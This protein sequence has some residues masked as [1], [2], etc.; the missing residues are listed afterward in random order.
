MHAAPAGWRLQPGQ[1]WVYAALLPGW[2]VIPSRASSNGPTTNAM[3]SKQ[4]DGVCVLGGKSVHYHTINPILNPSDHVL[5]YADIELQQVIQ[6]TAHCVRPRFLD[7]TSH[8]L[9]GPVV[10]DLGR[11][12]K[13]T[14]YQRIRWR[15]DNPVRLTQADERQYL[16]PTAEGSSWVRI[17]YKA[18]TDMRNDGFT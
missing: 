6:G 7:G 10:K 12:F 17:K 16:E 8:S 5:V 13:D 11:C 2:T 4:Y 1:Q 15:G 14:E 3:E 9:A 18:A